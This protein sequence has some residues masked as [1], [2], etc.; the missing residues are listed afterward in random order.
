MLRDHSEQAEA[1][2]AE[3][4]EPPAAAAAAA[5]APPR[6]PARRGA[7]AVAPGD[8]A[9]ATECAG[10]VGGALVGAVARLCAGGS[11]GPGAL[12]PR[13]AVPP[14]D[15]T[16]AGRCGD[17]GGGARRARG[18]AVPA[19]PARPAAL[20]GR[21]RVHPWQPCTP[22]LNDGLRQAGQAPCMHYCTSA[23]ATDSRGSAA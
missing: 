20:A 9:R 23:S 3:G 7:R 14:A 17:A 1:P 19:V 22:P 6:L 12:K 13:G 15:A 11:T 10:R 4:P 5:E 21:A 2:D 16:P 8:A 18:A